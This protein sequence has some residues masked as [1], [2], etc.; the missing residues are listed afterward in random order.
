VGCERVEQN[1]MSELVQLEQAIAHL[2][3]QR[4]SLGDAVVEAALAPLREKLSA[5]AAPPPAGQ[6]RKQVTILFGDVSGFTSLSETMDPEVVADTMNA[7]W[8]RIDAAIVSHGGSIDKHMGDG[9]MA[10]WGA[11]E[12]REDDPERAIRAGLEMRAELAAFREAQGLPLAMRVGIHTGA[13]LL[14]GVG[15][16]G[17]FSAMGDAVNLASRW[18]ALRPWAEC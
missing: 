9:V 10:L 13:A 14:G 18:R 6:E 8:Q 5:L 15:T 3:V 12:A 2:E 1:A 17:E 7:L 16:A 4:E 11:G